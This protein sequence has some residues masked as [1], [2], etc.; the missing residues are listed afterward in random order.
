MPLKAKHIPQHIL[1]LYVH[2]YVYEA[3]K[4]IQVRSYVLMVELCIH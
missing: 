4:Q 3:W 1:A 2:R